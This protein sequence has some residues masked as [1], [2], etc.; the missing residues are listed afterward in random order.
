MYDRGQAPSQLRAGLSKENY[1]RVGFAEAPRGGG[2]KLGLV[3]MA[4]ARDERRAFELSPERSGHPAESGANLGVN[5][6]PSES[7]KMGRRGQDQQFLGSGKDW[8]TEEGTGYLLGVNMVFLPLQF[9]ECWGK[10]Q[11]PNTWVRHPGGVDSQKSRV[12]FVWVGNYQST[13]PAPHH[14][15]EP[16]TC[17]QTHTRAHTNPLLRMYS[18]TPHHTHTHCPPHTYKHTKTH[19]H[20]YNTNE[21]TA[22]HT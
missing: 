5:W 15:T 3:N 10:S 22:R 11:E 18:H 13:R 19:T 14:C 21:H 4:K 2:G 16:T 7:R 1:A 8:R 17:I 20:I 9:R 12:M 6:G